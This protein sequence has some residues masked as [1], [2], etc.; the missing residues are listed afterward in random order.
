MPTAPAPRYALV[1]AVR[2]LAMVWMTL[3]HA[4]YDLN[5]LAI[6]LPQ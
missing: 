4:C 6:G 1:D 2:G 3:F 5:Y